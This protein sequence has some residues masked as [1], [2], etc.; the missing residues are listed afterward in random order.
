MYMS[1][2]VHRPGL[3]ILNKPA[4][5]YAQACAQYF[6]WHAGVLGR[7]K[8]SVFVIDAKNVYQLVTS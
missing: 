1:R 3:T 8:I 7:T 4:Q 5:A 6:R 2:V